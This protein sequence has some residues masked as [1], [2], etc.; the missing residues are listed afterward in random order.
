MDLPIE[1]IDLHLQHLF[2]Y[3]YVFNPA[4]VRSGDGSWLLVCRLQN[5]LNEG[6]LGICVLDDKFKPTRITTILRT[7]PSMED[8]S[9]VDRKSTV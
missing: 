1:V 9:D 5:H 7:S 8:A 4:M 2:G 6:Y 3:K